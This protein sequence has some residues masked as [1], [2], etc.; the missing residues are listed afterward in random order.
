MRRRKF[1]KG[2]QKTQKDSFGVNVAI[3]PVCQFAAWG[4]VLAAGKFRAGNRD[5]SSPSCP[6]AC[7]KFL[8]K[9]AGRCAVSRQSFTLAMRNNASR[10]DVC[11]CPEKTHTPLK[12]LVKITH[13]HTIGHTLICRHHHTHT[14][15]CMQSG[16]TPI[17]HKETHID[18]SDRL[19]FWS[20]LRTLI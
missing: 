9:Q 18:V 14:H 13:K 19:F 3:V 5:A 12:H 11:S 10:S 20:H 6:N 2:F 8:I 7:M 16:S 17:I 1:S 15:A 4:E